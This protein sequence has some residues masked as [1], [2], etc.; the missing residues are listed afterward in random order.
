MSGMS[1]LEIALG[2]GV[3]AFVSFV[4]GVWVTWEAQA[5]MAKHEMRTRG[6]R[7]PSDAEG[8]RAPQG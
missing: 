1:I 4:F 8:S 6:F 3:L 7:V 2:V 5:A